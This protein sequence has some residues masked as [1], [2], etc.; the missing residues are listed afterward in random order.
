VIP[1]LAENDYGCFL[2]D[3]TRFATKQCG[4]ARR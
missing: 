2:P 4:A 3:L 1:A